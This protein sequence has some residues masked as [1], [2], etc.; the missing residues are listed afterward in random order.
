MLT[1]AITLLAF[2]LA[3]AGLALGQY[4]GRAPIAGRCAPEGLSCGA[5]QCCRQ[6]GR[7]SA[8]QSTARE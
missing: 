4:F 3:A 1:I 7:D 6:S 2:L 8:D 5:P